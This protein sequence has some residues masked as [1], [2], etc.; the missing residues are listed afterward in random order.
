MEELFAAN[1]IPSTA[2]FLTGR[3]VG[4]VRLFEF[5]GGMFG[6][7]DCSYVFQLKYNKYSKDLTTVL[8]FLC[9]HQQETTKSVC[10]SASSDRIM[11]ERCC[12]RPLLSAREKSAE[13]ER[14]TNATAQ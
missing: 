6:A 5:L 3:G 4:G 10:Q 8:S 1:I 11:R 14:E 2:I 9:P 7:V 12:R 13:P